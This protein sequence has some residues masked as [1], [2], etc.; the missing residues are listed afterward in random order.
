MTAAE[1]P[2]SVC[3]SLWDSRED[4]GSR[5]EDSSVIRRFLKRFLT[6]RDAP[7]NLQPIPE[8]QREDSHMNEDHRSLQSSYD[9]QSS[10]RSNQLRP[11]FSADPQRSSSTSPVCFQSINI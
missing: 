6:K 8:P 11:D 7:K 1:S 9:S 5:P 3:G 10:D 2:A 4:V